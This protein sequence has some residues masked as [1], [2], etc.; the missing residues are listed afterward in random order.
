[1]TRNFNYTF[2]CHDSKYSHVLVVLL[3][4]FAI[5]ISNMIEKE[6][7]EG[8]RHKLLHICYHTANN[9]NA[10]RG[11]LYG[12]PLSSNVKIYSNISQKFCN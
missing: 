6:K 11:A 2:I 4:T 9:L 3:L 12:K 5:N 10:L 7:T 8:V 1:M